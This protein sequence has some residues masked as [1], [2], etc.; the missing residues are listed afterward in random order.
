MHRQ[1]LKSRADVTMVVCLG[2]EM[3]ILARHDATWRTDK[4]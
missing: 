1:A 2:W 3:R 4:Y